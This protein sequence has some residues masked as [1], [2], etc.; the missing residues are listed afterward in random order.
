MAKGF[1]ENEQMND[2]D[3]SQTKL[4]RKTESFCP[5]CV[6]KIPAEIV[7]EKEKV[8]MVKECP[9]HGRFRVFLSQH[10][11]Y[12]RGL[13]D[14]YFSLMKK[15]LPQHDYIL[16]L[17]ERCNLNC[18]ICL[19]SANEN[20]TIDYPI[21]RLKDFIQGKKGYKF[22]L[23]GTEPTMREDLPRIISMIHDSGNLAALHT[24]GIKIADFSYLKE[25]WEAGL[26]EVHFQFDGFDDQ[27]YLKVR[28]AKLL[29]IKMKALENLKRLNIGTDLV[30][31]ILRG[32]NDKEIIKI[33]K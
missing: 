27:F 24:N 9:Q 19:A 1:P 5:Q 6:Q 26:R 21:E 17:T 30:A 22:D 4:I 3:L 16:R 11:W 20:S 12:Y 23:M 31:T 13:N 29:S 7:E 2:K 32:Y 8:S 33:L 15:K 10:P 18:S 14:F 25:L 28:G